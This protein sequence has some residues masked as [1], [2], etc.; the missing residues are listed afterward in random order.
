MQDEDV[1]AGKMDMSKMKGAILKILYA[2]DGDEG[3]AGVS[4]NVVD[5]SEVAVDDD[6]KEEM[7][8]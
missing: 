6:E 3:D 2:E 8:F 4:S 5:G 7:L 1:T